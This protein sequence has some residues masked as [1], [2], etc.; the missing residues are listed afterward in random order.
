[1]KNR[2]ATTATETAKPS[3][4]VITFCLGPTKGQPPLWASRLFV[5]CIL[6]AS[7]VV[8]FLL[9]CVAR[10]TYKLQ[11]TPNDI[12]IEQLVEVVNNDHDEDILMPVYKVSELGY[13]YSICDEVMVHPGLITHSN[14]KVKY[15]HVALFHLFSFVTY[16]YHI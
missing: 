10:I 7:S 6:F 4:N 13:R 5:I 2:S 15:Y 14:P 9:G 3:R 8:A 11:I 12:S 16:E 1:M